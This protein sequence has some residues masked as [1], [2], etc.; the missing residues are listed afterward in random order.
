MIDF[1]RIRQVLLVL[2]A[3]T[4]V[5]PANLSQEQPKALSTEDEKLLK[6][7]LQEFLADPTGAVRVEVPVQIRSVWGHSFDAKDSGWLK[8]DKGEARVFFT[9]RASI[10]APPEEATRRID[11]VGEC[12]KVYDVPRPPKKELNPDTPGFADEIFRKMKRDAVGLN[13]ESDL[14]PVNEF[15]AVYHG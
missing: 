2:A 11:F 5:V 1:D 14:G 7:M 8:I 6:G 12:R 9:D 15:S 10:S 13:V 3:F 4:I